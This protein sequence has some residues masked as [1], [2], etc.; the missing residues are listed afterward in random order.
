MSSPSSPSHYYIDPA[1][2]S[3]QEW[4]LGRSVELASRGSL[5]ISGLTASLFDLPVSSVPTSQSPRPTHIPPL[6]AVQSVEAAISTF[7]LALPFVFLDH[8]TNA[9][10]PD[11]EPYD[12]LSDPWWIMLHANL[13]TAEMLM[14]KELAH[15]LQDAYKS[16]VSCARAL[17]KLVGRI[18][19][20]QWG[21]VGE[22]GTRPSHSQTSRG[23]KIEV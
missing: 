16:A 23:K 14:Y 7:R 4:W 11:V 1:S 18:R 15:H 22:F 6:S 8:D 19:P 17:V 3:C 9:P 10:R 20:E 2:K 12:G 5:G 21:H 13:Y